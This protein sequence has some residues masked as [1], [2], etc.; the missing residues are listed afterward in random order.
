MIGLCGNFVTTKTNH[1][2]FGE[3]IKKIRFEK[4]LGLRE[5]CLAAD[6]DPS[7]WSKVE[8]GVLSPPQDTNVLN[9]IVAI[10]GLSE[11]S[12]EREL[13]FD[14]AAIDAGKIPGYVLQDAELV[15]R[16]PVFFRTATG[17]KPTTEDLKKLAEILKKA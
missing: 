13:I 16:L 1:V 14:Y 4:R 5:F 9:R 17:K 11:N 3:L 12:K 15:K 2:M 8:R 6:W 10:L 7:N